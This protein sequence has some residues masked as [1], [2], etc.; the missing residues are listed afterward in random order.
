[1]QSL[2]KNSKLVRALA[3]V[4]AGTTTPQKSNGVLVQGFMGFRACVSFGAITSGAVTSWQLQHSDTDVDGDYVNIAGSLTTIVDTDDNT[5]S[6]FEYL[7]PTKKYVRIY[8]NRATQN[9]V[10][11]LGW[12]E[13]FL[14]NVAP[15]TPDA[16]VS[17]QGVGT[18]PTTGTP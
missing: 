18:Y 17:H 5:I 13:V 16:T 6:T 15:V 14:P 12:I 2:T 3:P 1:M 7:R 8:I 9:S 4:A 11:D 10:I